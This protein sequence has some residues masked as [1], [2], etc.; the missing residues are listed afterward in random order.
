M[1]AVS[2]LQRIKKYRENKYNLHHDANQIKTLAFLA[3]FL[4]GIF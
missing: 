3:L 2:N 4:S 1:F